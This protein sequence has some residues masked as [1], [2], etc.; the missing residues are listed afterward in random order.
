[1]HLNLTKRQFSI[2]IFTM[3]VYAIGNFG[4]VYQSMFYPKLAD[5]KGINAVRY[6]SVFFFYFL[7]RLLSSLFS[8]VLVTLIDPYMIAKVGTFII[9]VANIL[10]GYLDKIYDISIF[11]WLSYI[12]RFIEAYGFATFAVSAFCIVAK[13]FP[14]NIG[15][16]IGIFET[17]HGAGLSF[18]PIIGGVLYFLGGFILP[19]VALG[20]FTVFVGI[21]AIFIKTSD[22]D[23]LPSL[24]YRDIFALFIK[25]E[26]LIAL[27]SEFAAT[28]AFGVLNSSVE[29]HL[30]ILN[31][32]PSVIS[33]I[34]S[35]FGFSY[36]ISSLL[37]GNLCDR[38][39][40]PQILWSIGAFISCISFICFGPAPYLKISLNI[41]LSCFCFIIYGIGM[42][43]MIIPPFCYQHK[44]TL[45]MGF[46]DDIRTY[47]FVS[48]IFQSVYSIGLMSGTIVGGILIETIGLPWGLHILTL[49]YTL[50]IIVTILYDFIYKKNDLL[51]Q[52]RPN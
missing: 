27:W 7:V 4:N 42:S 40:P 49:F 45:K 9:G 26:F 43:V 5:E 23:I 36:F 13:E 29:P 11:L 25:A 12:L 48:S 30:R 28:F 24:N 10:F 52:S 47:G 18:G 8:R 37:V 14:N 16:I 3:V 50:L 35:L 34:F 31:L 1:M 39:K 46:P 17:G 19:F 33:L 21:I 20:Y 22:A 2:L 6:S 51:N 41:P 44:V 38:G 32:S 15:F